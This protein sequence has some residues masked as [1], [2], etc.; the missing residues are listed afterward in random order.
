MV[1]IRISAQRMD[2]AS[3]YEKSPTTECRL[4]RILLDKST[5]K[6]YTG[7]SVNLWDARVVDGTICQQGVGMILNPAEFSATVM[8]SLD[9]DEPTNFEHHK[10]HP[11]INGVKSMHRTRRCDHPCDGCVVQLNNQ[12]IERNIASKIQVTFWVRLPEGYGGHLTSAVNYGSH[13]LVQVSRASIV[14]SRYLILHQ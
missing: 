12:F 13:M 14:T 5:L 6:N 8:R 7:S 11:V 2:D 4:T 1:E 9:L 10:K 3:S